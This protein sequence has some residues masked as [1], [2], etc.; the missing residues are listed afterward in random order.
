MNIKQELKIYYCTMKNDLKTEYEKLKRKGTPI[1]QAVGRG[2]I[3]IIDWLINIGK[4]SL[5]IIDINGER[6]LHVAEIFINKN[7]PHP[8]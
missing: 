3:Q 6:L 7:N 5:N 4:S 1:S 8:I 2:T